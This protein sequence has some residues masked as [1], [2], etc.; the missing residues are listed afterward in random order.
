MSKFG[1]IIWY[2]LDNITTYSPTHVFFLPLF[3]FHAH[4][5]VFPSF[6][7]LFPAQISSHCTIFLLSEYW[8]CFLS[9][10]PPW[11]S[12]YLLFP[13][14]KQNFSPISHFPSF[15]FSFH[16]SLIEILSTLIFSPQN[17][18]LHTH[19]I[20]HSQKNQNIPFNPRIFFFET[21]KFS[22]HLK[23]TF[24]PNPISIFKTHKISLQTQDQIFLKLIN[25]SSLQKHPFHQPE[26][27]LYKSYNKPLRTLDIDHQ[28]ENQFILQID[29]AYIVWKN[30]ETPFLQGYIF[31]IADP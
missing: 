6:H 16:L 12:S 15:L 5:H 31:K 25:F 7:Y 13:S 26:N 18:D 24:F 8:M 1:I 27:H 4:T 21:Q 14:D 11:I 22:H 30:L 9:I 2:Y 29:N 23:N 10:D 28:P 3:H 19:S 17:Q 20:L